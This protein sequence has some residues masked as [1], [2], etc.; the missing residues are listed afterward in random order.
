MQEIGSQNVFQVTTNN[1][2]YY[3][4]ACR[5]LMLRYPTLF[6]TP[7]VAYCIDFILEDMRKIAYSNDI[8]E[9]DSNITKSI[10]NHISVLSLMRKFT[11]NRDLVHFAITHFA[12]NFI[13]LQSLLTCMWEA[14]RMFLSN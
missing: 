11:N 9:S 14:K 10:Y 5:L 7:C 12:T 6:W 2:V 1:I 13:S 3:V 4:V 8:V